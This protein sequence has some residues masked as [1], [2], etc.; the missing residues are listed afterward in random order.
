[1]GN[2]LKTFA[3]VLIIGGYFM[4]HYEKNTPH[5]PV[6]YCWSVEELTYSKQMK[7]QIYDLCA[8]GLTQTE[9]ITQLQSVYRK[10]IK[11][12]MAVQIIKTG[13][14]LEA[15]RQN[16]DPWKDAIRNDRKG[17]IRND[18]YSQGR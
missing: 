14:D 7:E 1:M 15:M 3:C 11:P 12:D 5:T 18:P 16:P 2:L 10:G 9:A 13:R 4:Y 6:K 8:A 17:A